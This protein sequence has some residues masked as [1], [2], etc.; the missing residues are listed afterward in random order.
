MFFLFVSYQIWQ[1]QLT[2]LVSS[3]P[4]QI[5]FTNSDNKNG[6]LSIQAQLVKLGE[7]QA[8]RAQKTSDCCSY[9]KVQQF[10][11]SKCFWL[12]FHTLEMVIWT[13]LYRVHWPLHIALPISSISFWKYRKPC[14]LRTLFVTK[15]L[16]GYIFLKAPL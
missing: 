13:V 16:V 2:I 8:E 1:F 12:F 15:G 3:L 11:S 7:L 4:P 14:A 9:P 6:V 10:F 5:K